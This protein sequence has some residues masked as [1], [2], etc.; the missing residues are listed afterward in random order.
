MA[1]YKQDDRNTGWIH[2][3]YFILHLHLHSVSQEAE[4]QRFEKETLISKTNEQQKRQKISSKFRKQ[5]WGKKKEITQTQHN[6]H[7]AKN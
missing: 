4:Q 2:T 1:S 3:Y 5:K 6:E 7:N